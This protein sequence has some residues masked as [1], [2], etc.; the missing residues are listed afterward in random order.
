MN[1]N[2]IK[3]IISN[4]ERKGYKD[5]YIKEKEDLEQEIWHCL[6]ATNAIKEEEPFFLF[7]RG[8][9][10]F[11]PAIP[12]RPRITL[13]GKV[14][15]RRMTGFDRLKE[16]IQLQETDHRLLT[17][18]KGGGC[19]LSWAGKGTVIDP[20]FDFIENM[21]S[22]ELAI[23]DIDAIIITHAHNDHYTD[24][25]SILTLIFQYNKLSNAY[26][27]I[28]TGELQ[29]AINFLTEL[30]E[31]YPYKF[32]YDAYVFCLD[33]IG[34]E[35]ETGLNEMEVKNITTTFTK[36]FKEKILPEIE[37]GKYQAK[38][39]KVYFS[40]S[41]M[42]SLKELVETIDAKGKTGCLGD[43]SGPFLLKDTLKDIHDGLGID[44]GLLET[45]HNDFKRIT[46][47]GLKFKLNDFIIGMTS[48]TAWFDTKDP[49]EYNPGN[50]FPKE[51]TEYFQNCQLLIPHIGSIKKE[52]FN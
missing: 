10:S 40:E 12:P 24:L 15:Q 50:N 8:Y 42:A 34:E 26:L 28:Q 11:T 16:L 1:I 5:F 39:V 9:N 21:Y 45:K 52:E 37:K 20:G 32:A 27:K 30:L 47:N 31:I 51:I 43:A 17:Y 29:K 18:V 36:D 4:L 6:K 19:F 7:L 41:A 48:D 44:I 22:E 38:I 33:A 14:S 25:V 46:G 3:E 23:G 13:R 49:M 35:K 2:A